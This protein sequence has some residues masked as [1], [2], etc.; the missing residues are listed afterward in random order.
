MDIQDHQSANEGSLEEIKLPT[1]NIHHVGHD[2]SPPTLSFL[3]GFGI[4]LDFKHTFGDYFLPMGHFTEE[5]DLSWVRSENPVIAFL[6]LLLGI[7]G[8]AFHG[9]ISQTADHGVF[10]FLQP[11]FDFIAGSNLHWSGEGHL[12]R[13]IFRLRRGHSHHLLA[14]V[15]FLKGNA[16]DVVKAF[17]QVGLDGMGVSSLTQNL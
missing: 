4:L 14:I 10:N 6:D 1:D 7:V 5:N 17:T 11:I 13:H 8:E 9:Q 15:R 12:F 2:E 16:V 3:H